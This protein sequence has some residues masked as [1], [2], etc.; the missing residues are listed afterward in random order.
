MHSRGV[1]GW[2][3]LSEM[4]IGGEGAGE[5]SCVCI[6]SVAID[7]LGRNRS[8]VIVRVAILDGMLYYAVG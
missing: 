3:K 5:G 8:I 2:L 4:C 1:V 7:A 6:E